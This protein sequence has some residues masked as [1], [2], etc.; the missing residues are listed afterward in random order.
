MRYERFDGTIIRKGT[1][2]L[3]TRGDEPRHDGA[4]HN[5]KKCS[6]QCLPASPYEPR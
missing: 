5:R 3:P 2:A 4:Q 1:T 6:H